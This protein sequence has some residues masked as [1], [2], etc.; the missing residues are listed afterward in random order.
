MRHLASSEP[1]P[2][3]VQAQ[4][5]SAGTDERARAV[6]WGANSHG[7]VMCTSASLSARSSRTHR[8]HAAVS[9]PLA[10]LSP[11]HALPTAWCAAA[12]PTRLKHRSPS[13]TFHCRTA[14]NRARDYGCVWRAAY[15][16]SRLG[17]P[18][19]VMRQLRGPAARRRS[20]RVRASVA[21]VIAVCCKRRSH[22]VRLRAFCVGAGQWLLLG[23]GQQRSRAAGS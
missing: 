1:E 9:P 11:S 19:V 12:A 13:A 16:A 10:R 23:M 4:A 7:Q 5:M 20:A 21:R 2:L 17:S 6:V 14:V 18:C 22:R 3:S 15:H 8:L